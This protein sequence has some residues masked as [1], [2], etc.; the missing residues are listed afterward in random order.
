MKNKLEVS[1]KTLVFPN[2]IEEIKK[3]NKYIFVRLAIVLNSPI[4]TVDEE[5]NVY[6]IKEDGEI[7]WQIKNIAPVEN[8]EF[9]CSPIVLMHVDG[10]RKTI[11]NRFFGK[12]I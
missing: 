1:G 7:L 4:N 8:P 12:K 9:V 2:D 10:K 5:C 6:A 3:N 11:C